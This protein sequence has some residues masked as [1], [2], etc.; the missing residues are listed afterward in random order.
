MPCR[1][2]ERARRWARPFGSRGATHAPAHARRHLSTRARRGKGPR[3]A[4]AR[5]RAPAQPSTAAASARRTFCFKACE[6]RSAPRW[7]C[8]SRAMQGVRRARAPMAGRTLGAGAGAGPPRA[9]TRQPARSRFHAR[10]ASR[11]AS[12]GRVRA[13]TPALRQRARRT[14]RSPLLLRRF[15]AHLASAL[16]GGLVRATAAPRASPS[17]LRPSGDGTGRLGQQPAARGGSARPLDPK[18]DDRAARSQPAR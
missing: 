8:A 18:V 15:G 14:A 17:T 9:P 6:A 11:R 12:S 2:G 13:A 7:S 3:H 5:R 10:S 4:A 16:S 1:G